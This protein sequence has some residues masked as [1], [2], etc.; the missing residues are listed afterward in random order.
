MKKPRALLPRGHAIRPPPANVLVFLSLAVAYLLVLLPW[1]DAQRWL[2]PEFV[3]LPLVYWHIHAPRPIGLGAAFFLGLLLD[4]TH[5][6]LI[7][8]YAVTYV[9]VAF[10]I[11]TLRRRLDRFP[12]TA[13]ALQVAPVFFGQA[14]LFWLIGLMFGLPQADDRFLAGTAITALLWWGLATTLDRLTGRVPLGQDNEVDP[15]K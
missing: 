11:L 9:L 12:P 10:V 8:L 15:R 1:P 4:L 5:G 14:V 2:L 3:L 6:I 7:G 13:Q